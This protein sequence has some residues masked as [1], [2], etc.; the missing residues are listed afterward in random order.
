[1]LKLISETIW[2]F[3]PAIVANIT[4]VYFAHYNWLPSLNKPLDGHQTWRGYRLL[5]NN[6]TVRGLISGIIA[7][8]LIGLMQFLTSHLTVSISLINYSS[9]AV[10]LTTGGLLAF[11]ALA[12]DAIASF[13]KRQLNIAPGKPWIP[14]DQIDFVIGAFLVSILFTPLTLSHLFIA[15]ILIGSGSYL[16]SYIGVTLNI[17]KSL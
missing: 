17:K 14:F 11:S 1:M 7:G 9:L 6:K 12:G 16:T 10:A 5:G 8:L 2:L 13:F 4:P 15:L 3:L